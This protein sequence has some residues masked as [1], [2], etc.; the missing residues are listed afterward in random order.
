MC[1]NSRV[2]MPVLSLIFR[3]SY[4]RSCYYTNTVITIRNKVGAKLCFLHVSVILFMGGGWMVSQ[5]A[6]QVVSQ[7]ALQQVWGGV[8]SQHALQVSRPTPKGEVKGSGQGGLKAHTWGVSRPTPRGVPALGRCLIQGGLLWGC[9]CGD[10]SMHT[11]YMQESF[12]V[13]N[14]VK[15]LQSYF[16]CSR[17]CYSALI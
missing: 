9:V 17:S 7:H 6:L 10:P 16:N 3:E 5:H 1:E 2:Y 8:V 11:K 15:V 4:L 12:N 13:C 14:W